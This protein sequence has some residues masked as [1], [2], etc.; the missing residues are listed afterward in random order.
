MDK[1]HEQVI[2]SKKLQYLH[3]VCG[4]CGLFKKYPTFG[5]EKYIYM[6]GVLK[7]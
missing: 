4:V 7:L 2:L 5:Q 3:Y 1:L 6:P